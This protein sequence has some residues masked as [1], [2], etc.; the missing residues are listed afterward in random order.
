MMWAPYLGGRQLTF[1]GGRMNVIN[2]N[3][4]EQLAR[5]Y[6]EENC[7]KLHYQ[8]ILENGY[9]AIFNG[10]VSNICLE[11]H[12][13]RYEPNVI[14]MRISTGE[15]YIAIGGDS[16]NGATSIEPIFN[17]EKAIEDSDLSE[18][19]KI[20]LTGMYSNLETAQG[21]VDSYVA[22]EVF[23]TYLV[24]LRDV[25]HLEESTFDKWYALSKLINSHVSKMNVE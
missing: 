2:L 10:Q 23:K 12:P 1:I 21:V 20:Q 24:C 25:G 18:D 13:E 16:Y 14:F 3:Q 22:Y 5:A 9:V 8:N 17:L 15:F 6:V 11:I 19:V 4:L 7:P